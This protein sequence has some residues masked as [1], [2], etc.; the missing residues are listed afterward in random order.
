MS[1][2]RTGA[3]GIINTSF[4][5]VNIKMENCEL[6]PQSHPKTLPRHSHVSLTVVAAV[7]IGNIVEGRVESR[8]T[9]CYDVALD[10]L[11]M[12][13]GFIRLSSVSP[14]NYLS[15]IGPCHPSRPPEVRSSAGQ[16]PHHYEV[17]L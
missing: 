6:G 13:R 12:K 9:F 3:E 17:S 2:V 14:F 10:E 5:R 11:A 16:A 8:V 7:H 4:S 15:T 1:I